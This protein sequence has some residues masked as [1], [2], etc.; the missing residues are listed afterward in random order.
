DC[1][2]ARLSSV[3]SGSFPDF[4]DCGTRV[5]G[6][7]GRVDY[8]DQSSDADA[9]IRG[10]GTRT[11]VGFE[12]G[13]G[14]IGGEYRGDIRWDHQGV[15]VVALDIFCEYSAWHCGGDSDPAGFDGTDALGRWQV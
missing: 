14:G 11:G 10:C 4:F 13:G 8:G 1:V 12:C 7:R 9:G 6:V 3:W 2:Y 5:A 15:L